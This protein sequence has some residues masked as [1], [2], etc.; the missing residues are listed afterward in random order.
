MF[1]SSSTTATSSVRGSFTFEFLLRDECNPAES[2]PN[3]ATNC[4]GNSRTT[5]RQRPRRALFSLHGGVVMTQR[6][7]GRGHGGPQRP[8]LRSGIGWW[9]FRF[10]LLF[11]LAAHGRA[12]T[13]PDLGPPVQA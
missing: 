4:H 11:W 6:A 13:L 12:K 10:L 1:F 7:R 5:P 8:P 3:F 9:L 2:C